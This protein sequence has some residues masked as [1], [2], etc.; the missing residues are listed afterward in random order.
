MS[1]IRD[2][3]EGARKGA[4]LLAGLS[5][6]ERTGVLGQMAT[7][8]RDSA[9][10]ILEAN[11]LDLQ[12]AE[13]AESEG[14]LAPELVKR[15]RLSEG[16]IETL[17]EGLE[18]L[19]Q[20]EEPVGKV[21]AKR[22]LGDGLC[23]EEVTSPIGVLLVIFES[24]P[25][26][27]PQI[28]GL[29]IKSGNVLVLKGGKEASRSNVA[30]H[31]ALVR[32]F[33]GKIPEETVGLVHTRED[34]ASLLQLDDV[35]DL[36]VPRGSNQLVK[37]IQEN[38]RIPVLGHAD[39]VCHVYLDEE[40]D[41][42]MA[43]A[44]VEDSKLDYPAACNAMETLL[45]HRKLYES[46]ALAG[47]LKALETIQFQGGCPESRQ[48]GFPEPDSLHCEW[49]DSRAT[50]V[51]VNGLSEAVEHIHQ[52]GSGHTECIVT[53]SKGNAEAFLAQVDSASVF[54]NASTR[55]ADGFRYG[56]GAEVG[57]STSRI[58]ARGPV[59]VNGL[60]TTRWLLRGQGHTV[61]KVKEGKWAFDWK[62]LNG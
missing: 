15:L 45:V 37:H 6:K 25:D 31:G 57:I 11:A 47:L 3:A 44:I 38:T 22:M 55:F 56:L 1:T 42:E 28:A 36:V 48:L 58:H 19:A 7:C 49:G 18:T 24:R 52:H 39:G 60:L 50:I 61:T 21:K 34:I 29:A 10:D 30:I 35:I 54:H 5:T 16:R 9:Q 53:E 20:M 46:G 8:L 26:A 27:L 40:A 33:A 17:A 14:G 13:R 23:L 51:I 59:G 43:V 12:D 32:A 41:M 62:E 4:R 2:Q